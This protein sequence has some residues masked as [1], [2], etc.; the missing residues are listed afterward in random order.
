MKGVFPTDHLPVNKFRLLVEDLPETLVI[1]KLSGLED[2]LDTVELPD[3]T[4]ASGG[5]V[6]GGEF[7]IETPMDDS[8][9]HAAMDE[10]FKLGHDPVQPNYKKS[11]VLIHTSISGEKEVAYNILGAFVSKRKLPDLEM[12]NEGD[13]AIVEWTCK[14]DQAM[15]S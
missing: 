4:M 6:K 9:E 11:C 15:R 13:P 14:Y 8:A 10:W 5:N 2:E 7:T 12:A 3:R 1:T